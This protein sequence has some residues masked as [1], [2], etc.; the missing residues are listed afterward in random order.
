[1]RVPGI[2]L[3]SDTHF[4]PRDWE[5]IETPESDQII[6]YEQLPMSADPNTL[7]K[8]AVLKFNGGLGT[9]MG[10]YFTLLPNR[11]I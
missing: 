10:T 2:S 9:S 8:L 4:H 5:K 3:G 11:V 7:S 6:P 1:M